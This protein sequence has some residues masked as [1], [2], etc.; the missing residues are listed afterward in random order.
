[1]TE[2]QYSGVNRDGTTCSGQVQAANVDAVRLKLL[3]EGVQPL[4]IQEGEHAAVPNQ[5]EFV[6]ST[7]VKREDIL[8]FTREMAHLKQAN[9]P[10][11]KVMV[12]LKETASGEDLKQFI[13]GVEGGIRAGKS[14]HQSLIPFERDLGRQ[15]LVMVKAGEASGS[16][17]VVLKELAIQ[18]EAN[19]KLR[20][21][22]ISALTYPLILL[23][24]SL[25]SVVMLLTFV[26][27]QFRDIFDAMGDALPL[28]TK[29]VLQFS[30]LI[31]VNW[32]MASIL[33]AIAFLITSRWARTEGGRMSIDEAALGI[34]LLGKVIQNLQ[35]AVYFR[36]L[37]ML[38]QRGVPLAEALGISLDTVN[39]H[40]LRSEVKP[41]VDIVKRGK[42]L[43]EAFRNNR[44]GS[45]GTMQLIRVA[46]ESGQLE[47]TLLSLSER[48]EE[49]SRRT[50]TRVLS[51]I[52][53]LIIICL[54]AVVAFI[55][56]AILGGVLSI[57]ETI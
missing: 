10:L 13:Q 41:V 5:S 42:R 14:L 29:L 39:N 25:M 44:F 56:I 15:Y 26:V 24:V 4:Q 2:Y 47:Q 36:T 23:I 19:A 52:E 1:M 48:F 28:S 40:V 9:M 33:L 11:D 46:E 20:N 7:R 30:D 49:E 8:M 31:R 34:P 21:Y 22:L 3:S 17:G 57:N 27:P 45:R 16:L 18:L 51:T 43:S 32:M 55:I 12:I 6:S 35:F 37:G 50:M 53:P 38:M 54:G